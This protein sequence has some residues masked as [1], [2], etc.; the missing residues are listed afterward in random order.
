MDGAN[1]YKKDR[2]TPLQVNQLDDRSVVVKKLEPTPTAR[3]DRTH[4][5]VYDARSSVV[6]AV[7]LLSQGVQQPKLKTTLTFIVRWRFRLMDMVEHDDD[8]ATADFHGC[9]LRYLNCL[10]LNLDFNLQMGLPV[11]MSFTLEGRGKHCAKLSTRWC[12]GWVITERGIIFSRHDSR[13]AQPFVNCG[14][15][16]LLVAVLK[17]YTTE[18]SEYY[19]TIMLPRDESLKSP[20]PPPTTS[21][22]H[23]LHA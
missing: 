3:L 5:K 23:V 8:V 6:R 19:T 21:N 22:L 16:L 7:V 14:V 17:Y 12:R 18:A 10:K 13:K 4:D 11:C 2:T 1:A 15:V 9:I 20:N